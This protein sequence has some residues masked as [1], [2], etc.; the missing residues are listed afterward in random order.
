MQSDGPRSSYEL[1]ALANRSHQV[2]QSPEQ[3]PDTRRQRSEINAVRGA[4]T[5]HDS[6]LTTGPA[7]QRCRPSTSDFTCTALATRT[8]ELPTG[9]AVS[10]LDPYRAAVRSIRS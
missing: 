1:G 3:S 10:A 8:S 2:R 5:A 7:N 9:K 6:A 4:G